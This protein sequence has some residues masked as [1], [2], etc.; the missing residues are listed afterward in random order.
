MHWGSLGDDDERHVNVRVL[1]DQQDIRAE[2]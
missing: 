1:S 2:I